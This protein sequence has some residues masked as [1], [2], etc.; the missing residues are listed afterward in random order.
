MNNSLIGKLSRSYYSNHLIV[1]NVARF[2]IKQEGKIHEYKTI[3]SA[4]MFPIKGE[5]KIH[6]DQNEFHCTPGK[7][8]YIP[9]ASHLKFTILS[10]EPYKYINIFHQ[11]LERMNFEID[12]SKHSSEVFQLL[13]DLVELSN[14]GQ[15]HQFQNNELLKKL[16]SFLENCH[17][18]IKSYE[19]TIVNKIIEYLKQHYDE[20]IDL[21]TLAKLVNKKETQ[22]S[23]LFK[24]FT[25]KCPIEYL[26]DYRIEKATELIQTT[27]LLISDIGKMVGYQDPF[28]FSRLY[29]KRTGIAPASLRK[30]K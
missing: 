5:A 20:P 1:H 21:R 30:R 3:T 8:I 29:K 14:N 15:N 10:K 24:K 28:Y 6:V 27:D 26:I 12:I 22:V 9:F 11:Y 17:S 13:F 4:F 18:S 2:E 19:N 7:M 23:Y 25:N 16:F